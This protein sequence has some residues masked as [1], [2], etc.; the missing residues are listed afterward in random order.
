MI[1]ITSGL[2][3][4]PVGNLQLIQGEQLTQT[5]S[6]VN[7][8][9]EAVSYTVTLNNGNPAP[10][11]ISIN[12]NLLI[13]GS[14]ADTGE[15]N[16]TLSATK[17][18][19]AGRII[20]DSEDIK[21]TIKAPTPQKTMNILPLGDSITQARYDQLSYRYPLWKLLI[22]EG[23]DI[24]FMGTQNQTY[25][26]GTG[27]WPEYEGLQFDQDH[28]GHSGKTADWILDHLDD[29]FS[30]YSD[31]EEIA[32]IVLIH[33]GTNDLLW[34]NDEPLTIK[35]DIGDVIDKLRT[36]NPSIKIL[37]AKITPF[38]YGSRPLGYSDAFNETL[39]SLANE[40][41]Q[42]DSPVIIVDMA[43]GFDIDE[44]TYDDLHPNAAGEILMAQRW[45][46]ALIN[47]GLL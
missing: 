18:N 42:S 2:T 9:T 43:S 38:S 26:D 34:T 20:T 19:T 15:F 44:H 35:N 11:F 32:D 10:D 5:L 8:G 47:N 13:V 46:D 24:N 6:A 33:L 23:K 16:L 40:K 29:Y 45:F 3:L 22:D 12:D 25:H 21:I 30:S 31:S 17:N 36:H 4:N 39:D 41:S 1:T 28:E 7:L 37:L 27:S 14:N